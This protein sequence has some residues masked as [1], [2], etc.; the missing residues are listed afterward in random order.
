MKPLWPLAHLVHL[1]LLKAKHELESSEVDAMTKDELEAEC[2]RSAWVCCAGLAFQT[3]DGTYS[4]RRRRHLQE[5]SQTVAPTPRADAQVKFQQLPAMNTST[6]NTSSA[7]MRS[8][9]NH[10]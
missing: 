4:T 7:N 1:C 9:E 8:N 10:I 5:R 2:A 6:L 3:G